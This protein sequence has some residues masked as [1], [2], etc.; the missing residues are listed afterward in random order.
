MDTSNQVHQLAGLVLGVC[1]SAEQHVPVALCT[2]RRPC[3]QERPGGV[4]GS[5]M[6]ISTDPVW[7]S[8]VECRTWVPLRG[9]PRHKDCVRWHAGARTLTW[10]DHCIRSPACLPCCLL[11]VISSSC[12]CVL[13]SLRASMYAFL[14]CSR[15]MERSSRLEQQHS[16]SVAGQQWWCL[17][18]LTS[19]AGAL[20]HWWVQT[21]CACSGL[22]L[23]V[24]LMH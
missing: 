1:H 18:R 8:L 4:W 2:G 23:P 11:T 14:R 19:R 17:L 16:S 15:L 6:G 20:R 13:R 22:H 21:T 10:P 3:K 5:D 24:G 7:P 12:C 9:V